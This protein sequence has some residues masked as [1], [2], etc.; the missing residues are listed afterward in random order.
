MKGE[1]VWRI[2]QGNPALQ[3]IFQHELNISPVLARLLVNRGIYTVDDAR[4]FLGADTGL[5]YDPFLMADMDKAVARISSALTA[6]ERI[7][8]YGDY[9]ADGTTGT[10]LL[11]KVLRR[12]G[13]LV[14]YYVPNRI[15]EGYGLHLEVIKNA[16]AEGYKLLVT[17]DCGISAAR[18][19]AAAADLGGPDIVITDHH[20]PPEIIPPALAVVN[21]KRAGCPYPFK[22]LAGVGVALKL[23]QALLAK[24]GAGNGE[25]CDYL[26]LACLGTIADIV[27]LQ[28]ENR[29]LVKQGLPR[30]SDTLNPGLQ[31]LMSA[32]GVH[33]ERLGTR[34]VAF[35]LSPRLNAAGR[36]G[37]ASMAVE[38][39]LCDDPATAAELAGQLNRGNQERQKIESVVL[40]GALG[41]LDADPKIK[42]D[43]VIVLAS[44]GWHPGVIG[45][46]ASRLVERY[47]RPVLMIALD[48]EEGPGKGS[49]RSI[50]GFHLYEALSF[51]RGSLQEF[52]GHDQ[53]AGFSV[54]PG[55]IEELRRDINDYAIRH[56]SEDIYTPGL[57]LDGTISL[58]DVSQRLVEE[59]EM[60]SPFGHCNPGPLLACR[61]ARLLSCREV[62]K[63]GKHL[64]LL[65]KDNDAVLD[66]IAFNM[67]SS[68]GALE[69][70]AAV[71]VAFI[72]TLNQWNGRVSVQ[73]EVRDIKPALPRRGQEI[74]PVMGMDTV[75]AMESLD[76]LGQAA[77]LPEYI[78][79]CFCT[80]QNPEDILGLP[81]SAVESIIISS[82]YNPGVKTELCH[83]F[84]DWRNMPHRPA[85]LMALAR[86]PGRALVLV[87]APCRTVELAHFLAQGGVTADFFHPGLSR[88][89]RVAL[90]GRFAA[91]EFSVLVSTP[92]M[93]NAYA[94]PETERIVFYDLPYAREELPVTGKGDGDSLYL[95]YSDIMLEEGKELLRACF[96]GRE[97][98]GDIYKYLRR[99]CTGGYID[100]EKAAVFMRGQGL[101]RADGKTVAIALA[102]FS[103]LGIINHV[104]D[105]GA[106]KLNFLPVKKKKDLNDSSI[107]SLGQKT[108]EKVLGWWAELSDWR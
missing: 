17:V 4:L 3:L 58:G 82:E 9:D 94:W 38:M 20:E 95:L 73:L 44:R 33:R 106:Y 10:A 45:I 102:I 43:R 108:V 74:G 78:T 1:K 101:A 48:G 27:P 18:E 6:G 83:R 41:M 42:E 16:W 47:Y 54:S 71:D 89:E 105:Q 2:K 19:V 25:W 13:G 34:E 35:A 91:G 60:M 49:G 70:A 30:L 15:E 24:A 29:I 104:Y 77:F 76:N 98:L 31:A 52:G 36:V 75:N 96:P 53:A 103:E 88:E 39:L 92:G 87:N 59:L 97:E 11:V 61:E 50:P 12:L 37:D 100:P 99:E 62:G 90:T 22:E 72:P 14:G 68:A 63:A 28:G 93:L 107:Y 51:C 55:N 26:D 85:A 32:A 86:E 81:G 67:A 65:V 64:K 69:A 79:R 40:A 5:M 23:A 57:E 56:V 84:M 80:H 7:L 46:V 21:P 66:G 8:V